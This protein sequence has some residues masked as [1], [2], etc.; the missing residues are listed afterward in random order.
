MRKKCNAIL[1]CVLVLTGCVQ[2][3]EEIPDVVVIPSVL[4]FGRVRVADSPLS[5]SFDIEN[6]SNEPLKILDII[7]GC[8]CTVIDIPQEPIAT[9]EKKS[10][11]V[12]VN[13]YG[14]SGEF[15]N[16]VHIKTE[17]NDDL[18]VDINGTIPS[19]I[20]KVFLSNLLL[21]PKIQILLL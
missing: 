3:V 20:N 21:P 6:T 12:K 18:F 4:D 19:V 7:S 16:M 9:N 8:G 14:R 15:T 17:G 5:L 1:V 2:R 13:L 11:A 10:I